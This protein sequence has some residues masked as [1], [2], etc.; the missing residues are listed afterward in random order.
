MNPL[1]IMYWLTAAWGC[2]LIP[3]VIYTIRTWN[4]LC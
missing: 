1:D 4:D 3:L 2:I